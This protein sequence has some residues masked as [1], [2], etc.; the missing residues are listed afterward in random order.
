MS[1]ELTI[2]GSSS[3]T[4]NYNR[5]PTSQLL[6]LRERYFLIDCGEGTLMQLLRYRI[7]YHRI[8][9]IFISHLHGD[10]YFGLMGLL[11]TFHLQGRTKELH[12]FGQQEL[13][14]VIEL[15]L[16][17][18]NTI[19]RYNLIFHAVRHYSAEVIMEDDEVQIRSIVLNHRVPCTGFLFLEKTKPRKL[20]VHKLQQYNIPFSNYSAIKNGEDYSDDFGIKISNNELTENPPAPGTYAYCSDTIYDENIIEDVRNVELLYH[21]ATF[22]HDLLDRAVATYHSTAKQAAQIALGAGVRKLLI[23]HFSARYKELTPLLTEAADI[24]GRTELALEGKK[25]LIGQ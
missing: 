11:S 3:A 5:H 18:A 14:D 15:Q 17:L 8:S 7:K 12:L 6:N 9:H 16:R 20:L 23:G 24:F 21:E 10:H 1:F 4:P 22:A 25:F 2:L 13:M 19:L